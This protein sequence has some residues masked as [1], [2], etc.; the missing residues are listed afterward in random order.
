MQQAAKWPVQRSLSQRPHRT[1]DVRQSGF[2]GIGVDQTL[3]CAPFL[4]PLDAESEEVEA[5]VNVGD[6]RLRFCEPKPDRTKHRCHLLA[7]GFGVSARAGHQYDE[8]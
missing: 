5:L 2:V 6:P 8:V 7:Q 4:V 3:A 1:L